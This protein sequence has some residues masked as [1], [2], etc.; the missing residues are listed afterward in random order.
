MMSREDVCESDMHVMAVAEALVTQR[1]E[2]QECVAGEASRFL[3]SRSDGIAGVGEVGS[4]PSMWFD[5]G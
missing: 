4:R 3:L 1:L 5:C 2:K